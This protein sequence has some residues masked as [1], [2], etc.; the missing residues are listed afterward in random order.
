VL[1]NHIYVDVKLNGQGPFRFLFDTGG[2]NVIVPR[3]VEKLHLTAKGALE[4]RGAGEKSEDVA[5]TTIDKLELGDISISNQIFFVFPFE[6]L[7]GV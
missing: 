3:L 1:N 5:L 6:G 2:A 7:E 4:G